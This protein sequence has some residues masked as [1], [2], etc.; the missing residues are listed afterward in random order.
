LIPNKI[1]AGGISGLATVFYYLAEF[2]VGITMLIIN[3][4]ILILGMKILGASFGARTIYGI[5]MLSIFTDLFQPIVVDITND[6]LLAAIYGGLVTGAGLGI[7]FRSRGTTGGTDMIARLIHKFSGFSVG[8]SL[9]IADGFVVTLAGIFFSL[10]VALYAA[11]SIFI[12]SKTIDVIQ[13]GL[14]ISK[15]AQIISDK[16][17][18]IEK[19]IIDELSRGVTGFQARGGY[20][21]KNKEVLLCIISRSEVTKLKQLVYEI[22]ED[23]FVIITSVHEVLG[24]GFQEVS[25][26]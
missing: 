6:L 13:E 26:E 23:A 4:P 7:V 16:P 5:I 1:A 15:A 3:I 25:E 21:G 8:Q 22:D 20:T 14:D 19:M 2:P 10:E 9:L 18:D 17:G 11:I 24:E 12:N